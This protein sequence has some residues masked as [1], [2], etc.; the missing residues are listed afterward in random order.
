MSQPARSRGRVT[1]WCVLLAVGAVLVAIPAAAEDTAPLALDDFF[2]LVTRRPV[3]E[4]EL[5]LRVNTAKGREGRETQ[6]APALALPIG[7]WWQLTLEMPVVVTDPRS[8]DAAGGAG[9]LQLEVS[10]TL[11]TGSERRDL[12]GELAIE[13]FLSVG[14]LRGRAYVVAEIAYGWSLNDV[15]PHP[16][17]QT[18][19][20][21]VAAGYAVRPWLIPLVELTTVT[22]VEGS[23]QPGNRDRRGQPQL[24]ITPGVNAQL[25][26]EV[27]LGLGI[28]LPVTSARTFDYTLHGTL[29]WSF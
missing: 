6:I 12:G 14:T 4:R 13:P 5:E 18:L 3:L 10:L 24:Y 26:R 7:S 15:G 27:T 22:R 2:P 20:A 8:R 25:L 11:P 17:G 28:Q 23:P 9:D 19:T 29:D 1:P 21:G 16:K